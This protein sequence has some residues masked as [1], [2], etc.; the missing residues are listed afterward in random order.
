MVDKVALG[1]VFIQSTL[2]FP[3]H[4]HSCSFILSKAS[5]NLST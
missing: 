2:V 5:Y 1:Q 4:Y 3:H